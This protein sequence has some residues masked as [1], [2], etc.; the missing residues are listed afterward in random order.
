MRTKSLLFYFFF[1]I[2]TQSQWVCV[3]SAKLFA[4]HIVFQGQWTTMRLSDRLGRVHLEKPSWSKTKGEVE[5][6]S[7]WSKRSASGRYSSIAQFHYL[8]CCLG[9]GKRSHYIALCDLHMHSSN[10]VMSQLCNVC[11]KHKLSLSNIQV[12]ALFEVESGYCKTTH[13]LQ[14][15]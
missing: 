5:T 9:S 10:F 13:I 11:F 2:I 15:V 14:S 7:V 3:S 12:P 6:H 1:F 8:Q 4:P